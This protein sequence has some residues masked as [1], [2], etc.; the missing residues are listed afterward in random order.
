M[1]DH[2]PP[3]VPSSRCEP[4]APRKRWRRASGKEVRAGE[5]LTSATHS[6][7]GKPRWQRF[8]QCF[9]EAVLKESKLSV[10][11]GQI[12]VVVNKNERKL[13]NRQLQIGNR[14]RKTTGELVAR[15]VMVALGNTHR[16]AI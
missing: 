11:F 4:P 7:R 10:R 3:P 14:A 13:L 5:V 2:A 8:A 12:T 1:R 9:C 15:H 6:L 16:D